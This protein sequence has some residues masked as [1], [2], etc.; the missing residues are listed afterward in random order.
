MSKATV[1]C[2]SCGKQVPA[3]MRY[4]GWCGFDMKVGTSKRVDSLP[5]P[6]EKQPPQPMQQPAQEPVQPVVPKQPAQPPKATKAQ[7]PNPVQEPVPKQ[8]AVNPNRMAAATAP[9]SAKKKNSGKAAAILAALAVIVLVIVILAVIFRFQSQPDPTPVSANFNN[10]HV[11]DA[12]ESATPAPEDTAAP[13]ATDAPTDATDAP[14]PVDDETGAD[15]NTDEVDVVDDTVYVTGSGV[16]LRTGPGT[17]FEVIGSLARGTELKR[18]GTTNGWSRV[19]YND[20][21]CYISSALISNEKPEITEDS[22]PEDEET[23]TVVVIAKANIRTGPGTGYKS[24]G[25]LDV[26]TELT[27]TGTSGKWTIVSYNGGEGYIFNTLI[28]GKGEKGTVTV[29][30]KANIRAGAGTDY[31]ILGVVNVG[32]VLPMNDH[33]ASN[34]Y[35][36][37]FD[38]KTGYIAGNMVKANG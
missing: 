13:D 2:P 3:A 21:T 33:T 12:S 36:V 31:D 30:A 1:K 8:K 20:E 25:V 32:D 16:N 9:A 18:T 6:E 11:V 10:V 22:A 15:A 38:G 14:A 4:C 34:W 7:K 26:G 24:L 35:E 29:I 37:E 23:S 17:T 19:L 27:C 5:R 28:A